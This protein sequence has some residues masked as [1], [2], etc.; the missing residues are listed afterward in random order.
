[1]GLVVGLVVLL[2]FRGTFFTNVKLTGMSCSFPA[3]F[4]LIVASTVSVLLFVFRDH[5]P[6]NILLLILVHG[7]SGFI[8]GFAYCARLKHIAGVASREP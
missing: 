1:M 8:V 3:T 7:G 6:V 5:W 4:T 2:V